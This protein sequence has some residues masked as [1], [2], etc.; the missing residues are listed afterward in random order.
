MF[1]SGKTTPEKDGLKYCALNAEMYADLQKLVSLKQLPKSVCVSE[2]DLNKNAGTDAAGL[3]NATDNFA[4][5]NIRKVCQVQFQSGGTNIQECLCDNASKYMN[6][7][8][9]SYWNDGK[10]ECLSLDNTTY[11]FNYNTLTCEEK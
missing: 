5:N 2:R 8:I 1:G 3:I 11:E 9:F 4:L 7:D 10:C 6:P